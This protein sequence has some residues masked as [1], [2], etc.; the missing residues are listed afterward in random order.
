MPSVTPTCRSGRVIAVDGPHGVGKSLLIS[1]MVPELE[2]HL[3]DARIAVIPSGGPI[4]NEVS[5]GSPAT[6][7]EARSFIRHQRDR[8]RTLRS[9]RERADILLV[10]RFVA[11]LLV[12]QFLT[13]ELCL[14]DGLTAVSEICQIIGPFES[15]LL[16]HPCASL[17]QRILQRNR[18]TTRWE[19]R[20]IRRPDLYDRGW[21]FMVLVQ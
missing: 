3:N 10:D 15:V 16:S 11:S 17:S 7:T 20:Q 14:E 1:R 4:M 2:R 5:G 6:A 19:D 18:A 21:A 13:S 9:E 8:A 12:E